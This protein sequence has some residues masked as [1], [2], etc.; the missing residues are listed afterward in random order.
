MTG[1][2]AW[3]GLGLDATFLK[4]SNFMRLANVVK[5]RE[6]LGGELAVARAT[7]VLEPLLEKAPRSRPGHEQAA[8]P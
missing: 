3:V 7:G 5:H 8:K 1:K 4:W 6:A 2:K